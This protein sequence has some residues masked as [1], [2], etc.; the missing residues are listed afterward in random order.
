MI[1]P[2]SDRLARWAKERV[3]DQA[4][5]SQGGRT[6]LARSINTWRFTGS[7]SGSQAIFNR[8]YVPADKLASAVFSPAE[9]RYT[10]EY[11]NDY[12]PD[13]TARAKVAA[14]YL[15]RE[16]AQRNL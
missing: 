2:P 11:E 12:G 5:Y 8:L 7:D 15:S 16:V 10:V 1:L 6:Q 3:I 13:Q 9:L 4:L 14:R